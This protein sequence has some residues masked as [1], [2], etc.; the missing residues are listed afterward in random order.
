MPCPS[1]T[2]RPSTPAARPTGELETGIARIFEDV[3]GL[4]RVGADDDFFHL[5]GHSLLATRI[6]LRVN[7]E[8]GTDISLRTLFE[9]PTVASLAGWL[10]L[11]PTTS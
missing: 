5:G 6:V 9:N 11:P 10:D 8:F 3:L 2:T 1:P 7:Q 4:S